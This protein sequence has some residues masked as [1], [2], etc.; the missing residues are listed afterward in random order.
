MT[1]LCTVCSIKDELIHKFLKHCIRSA[2]VYFSLQEAANFECM[3][4][5]FI[6]LVSGNQTAKKWLNVGFEEL[7]FRNYINVAID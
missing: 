7:S 5:R 3:Q 6:Y 1:E 2:F 4:I